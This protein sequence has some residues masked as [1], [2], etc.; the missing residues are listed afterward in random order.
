MNIRKHF[1]KKLKSVRKLKGFTQEKLA[2]QL[3]LQTQSISQIEN[4][5]RAVSFALL[6]NIITVL[7]VDPSVL[8]TFEEIQNSSALVNTINKELSDL[9][10]DSLRYILSVIRN[11][12]EYQN[13]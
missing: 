10:E 5:R 13:S 1:G 11:F 12:K 3:E 7:K 9:D 6:E 4:G 2:E 8:F